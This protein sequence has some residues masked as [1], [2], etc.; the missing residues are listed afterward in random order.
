M[1]PSSLEKGPEAVSG[2]ANQLGGSATDEAVRRALRLS[3]RFPGEVVSELW[4]GAGRALTIGITGPPGVGKST[5]IPGLVSEIR[6]DSQTVGVIAVDPS[7][8]ISGGSIM[9]DRG[10]IM[11]SARRHKYDINADKG[12]WIR[13]FSA[14]GNLGGVSAATLPAMLTFDV[15]GKDM[16]VVETVGVGQ[17]E[18]DIAYIVDTTVVVLQPGSGDSLQAMKSGLM[19]IP[20]VLCLNRRDDVGDSTTNDMLKGL[21]GVGRPV[22]EINANTGSGLNDLYEA[23]KAHREKLGEAGLREKRQRSLSV[24][25]AQLSVAYSGAAIR[26]VLESEQGKE[27]LEE[28]GDRHKDPFQ[29][30]NELRKLI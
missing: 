16:I 1:P 30:A 7:S 13:S 11:E 22:V 12:V 25:L 2:L 15:A 26:E 18:L 21:R 19:E 9:G 14:A 6:G 4:G 23:I 28:V 29:A 10:T 17:S 20:D 8:P 24:Q 27:L 3:E 5:L